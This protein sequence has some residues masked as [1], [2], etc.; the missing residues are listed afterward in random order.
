MF[1]IFPCAVFDFRGG[2]SASTVLSKSS[3][4]RLV[5]RK[6]VDDECV[7]VRPLK[8]LVDVNTDSPASGFA[9][10]LLVSSKTKAVIFFDLRP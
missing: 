7:V 5:E 10:N 8:A 4:L 6:L 1:V 3:R 2:S 9:K